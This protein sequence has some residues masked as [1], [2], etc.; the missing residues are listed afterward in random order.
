MTL[1][2]QFCLRIG[3]IG[4]HVNAYDP[5]MLFLLDG[6]LIQFLADHRES[7]IKIRA[8]R[9]DLSG[10]K[11]GEQLFDSGTVWRAYRE[12]GSYAFQ[13]N[14]P[15]TGPIPYKVAFFD[16]EFSSGKIYFH[17][18]YFNRPLAFYPLEYP[19]DE[20]LIVN[21]LAEGKGVE[22]HACGVVDSNGNG[23]LFVGQSEAGKTTMARL[24]ESEPGIT[25]LSDDRIILRKMENTIWMYGTPWHGEAM[26]ASPTRVPLTTVY[27]LE[28]G[29][30]NELISQKPSGS[31]SRLFASSFPP[32][33]NRDA[34]NFTLTFLEGVVKNVPCYE[35]KFTPDRSVVEFIK[36][37][38]FT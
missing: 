11:C 2:R 17:R 36:G 32:F 5:E 14:S 34:L 1:S 22:V 24:W 35:L 16:S 28:K 20:L 19:L 21:L 9:R 38:R 26:L 6:A 29:Q 3:D 15:A 23:H 27:F 12:N 18:A 13:F 4:I 25:V 31:I 33:Y 10:V 8:E 7:D 30:K 37:E